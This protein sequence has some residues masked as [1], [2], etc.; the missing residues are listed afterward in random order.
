MMP[1]R[2]RSPLPLAPPARTPRPRCRRR[3]KTGH[4]RMLRGKRGTVRENSPAK[5]TDAC[6]QTTPVGCARGQWSPA[7]P[8][9]SQGARPCHGPCRVD[10]THPP[11]A[12]STG[13]LPLRQ[14]NESGERPEKVALPAPRKSSGVNSPRSIT[15]ILTVSPLTS[16]TNG[17][18]KAIVARSPRPRMPTGAP[19]LVR[20][21]TYKL[22]RRTLL[23]VATRQTSTPRGTCSSHDMGFNSAWQAPTPHSGRGGSWSCS[24]AFLRR[25]R[26][27]IASP[28]CNRRRHIA[29]EE[30]CGSSRGCRSMPGIPRRSS[31]SSRGP[32]SPRRSSSDEWCGRNSA[33]RL[34]S[35]RCGGSRCRDVRRHR[36]SPTP[37]PPSAWAQRATRSTWSTWLRGLSGACLRVR[38]CRGCRRRWGSSGR[39]SPRSRR[40]LARAKGTTRCP[41][42]QPRSSTRPPRPRAA[43]PR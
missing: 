25:G 43:P 11:V 31:R 16:S 10:M 3:G 27:R 1:R 13:C 29:C 9:P 23:V 28:W 32:S 2:R 30:P 40:W 33:G 4:R 42:H 41:T 35:P 17:T 37:F 24:G 18:E 21:S 14:L 19:R 36:E 22:G 26:H 7:C 34:D 20:N 38:P 6:H 15:E 5:E 8:E 12:V 39:W